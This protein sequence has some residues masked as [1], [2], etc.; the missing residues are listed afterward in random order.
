MI[1]KIVLKNIKNSFKNF[2]KIYSLL[3]VSQL[4]SILSIFFVYGIFTSYSDKMTELDIESYRI[5]AS[6]SLSKDDYIKELKDCL[7]EILEPIEQKLDFMFVAGADNGVMID[8]HTEYDNGTYLLSKTVMENL[9]LEDGRKLSDEDVWQENKVIYSGR[10]E[11]DQPG[12]KISIAGTEFEVVGTDSNNMGDFEIPFS[13]CPDDVKLCYA[14]FIF[15]ELPTQKDY[16]LI[17]NTFDGVFGANY[18][19]EEFELQNEETVIS[20]R[21]NMVISIAIC[22]ISALNTCLLY[23]YIV[24]QRR[25]QM[26]VYGI[27]GASQ[28]RRLAINE[29]E[30]MLVSGITALI[31]FVIFKLGLE[32][33]ILSIYESSDLY[34]VEVYLGMIAGY[35]ISIFVFTFILLLTMNRDKL[36]DMLRR[37]YND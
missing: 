30:I 11:E 27:I 12:K 10:L 1:I 7:P 36:A 9:V 17:K 5:G 31:G 8:M 29:V 24:S 14:S 25:K 35:V 33:I 32:N 23:G 19:L 34:T 18:E 28:G 15:K 26:A 2:R 20:Y 13:V 37:T 16:D 21:T 22:V 3:I 6:F 4:V